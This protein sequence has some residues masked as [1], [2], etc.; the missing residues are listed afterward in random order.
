MPRPF[1]LFLNVGELACIYRRAILHANLLALNGYRTTFKTTRN[2]A[3]LKPFV[4]CL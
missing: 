3:I 4:K 1:L 2:L